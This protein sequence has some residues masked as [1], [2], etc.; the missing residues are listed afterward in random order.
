MAEPRVL[1][2]LPFRPIDDRARS[3]ESYVV[4]DGTSF[5][6]A[7]WDGAAFVYPATAGRAMATA[8]T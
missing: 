3:G 5:A 8:C 7:R 1:N 2:R 4:S 6:L